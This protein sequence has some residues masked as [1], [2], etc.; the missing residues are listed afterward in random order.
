VPTTR[1]S[2]AALA[3]QDVVLSRAAALASYLAAASVVA[4]Y[5]VGT[6]ALEYALARLQPD[7]RF[8]VTEFAPRTASRLADLMPELEV[9]V[10]DLTVD[11]PVSGADLHLLVRIDTELTDDELVE[12]F[13]RFATCRVVFVATEV[14]GARSIARELV[15]RIRGNATVAGWVRSRGALEA[16]WS[17]THRGK[18]VAVHDLTAWLLDPLA[19]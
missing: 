8:I 9:R 6:G 1:S 3:D 7:R 19:T 12:V 15:T 17:R 4:S 14:L 5:G 11:E 10:H 13:A 18:R 16:T 2:L